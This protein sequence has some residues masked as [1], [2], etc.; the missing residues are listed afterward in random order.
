MNKNFGLGCT[1]VAVAA[2]VVAVV[3]AVVAV[4]AD[5]SNDLQFLK[6]KIETLSLFGF[7]IL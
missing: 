4:V 3:D 5:D 6:A 2:V 7:I 1:A